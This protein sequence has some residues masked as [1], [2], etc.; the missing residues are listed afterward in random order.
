MER[1]A[2]EYGYLIPA[3]AGDDV[4]TASGSTDSPSFGRSPTPPR[5]TELFRRGGGIAWNAGMFLWQRGAILDALRTHTE[6]PL[7]SE[8]ALRAAYPMLTHSLDRLRG[9]GAGGGRGSRRDGVDGRRLGRHRRL[10]RAPRGDRPR[11]VGSR[12]RS[13]RDDRP[14]ARRPARALEPVRPPRTGRRPGYDR[15]WTR[16]APTSS[17]QTAASCRP[18]STGW[19][20]SENA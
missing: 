12:R 19:R 2:T 17:A 10:D 5:P 4:A 1:P 20:Q 15:R 18:C 6:L 7:A 16:R 3:D 13:R 14:R 9:D 11:G 8:A